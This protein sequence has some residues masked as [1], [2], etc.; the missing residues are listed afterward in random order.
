[1]IEHQSLGVN[2]R[3]LVTL[4]IHNTVMLRGGCVIIVFL[5]TRF[6]T[7]FAALLVVCALEFKFEFKFK[8][9]VTARCSIRVRRKV[10]E[11]GLQKRSIGLIISIGD[12]GF[13]RQDTEVRKE[14]VCVYCPLSFLGVDLE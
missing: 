1:M 10:C 8:F 14:I 2:K 6:R 4:I 13:S 7:L 3:W 11:I 12:V 9:T 5:Q